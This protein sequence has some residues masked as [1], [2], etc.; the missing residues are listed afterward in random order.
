MKIL[1]EEITA[2]LK[3]ILNGQTT[4]SKIKQQ[5]SHYFILLLLPLRTKMTV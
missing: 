5:R 2:E 4:L 3:L 1:W